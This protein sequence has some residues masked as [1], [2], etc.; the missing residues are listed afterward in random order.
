MEEF[1]FTILEQFD[2]RYLCAVYN[3]PGK[4]IGGNQAFAE[5]IKGALSF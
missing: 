4:K 3:H 1:I 5:I 2:E